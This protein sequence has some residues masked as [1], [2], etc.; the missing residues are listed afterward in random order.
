MATN[1]IQPGEVI[2]VAAPATVTSGSPVLAGALFGVA[3]TDAAPGADVEIARR[4]V[5]TLPKATGQA[6]TAGA[7]VYWDAA[8]S[9]GTTTA[10]SN[11]LIGAA[12]EAAVSG[13]T[14]GAV[15]LDGTIR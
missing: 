10:G 8:A 12:T 7:K 14:E 3:Q 4:G 1:F 11:T 9:R 13:A 5:F 2:T 15:L 6:W